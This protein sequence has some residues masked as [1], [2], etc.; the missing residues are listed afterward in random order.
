MKIRI[1]FVS[2]SS[3]SSFVCLGIK[4]KDESFGREQLIA[5][6]EKLNI[7]NKGL[8]KHEYNEWCYNPKSEFILGFSA[9]T[10]GCS[11]EWDDVKEK[12][13]ILEK[14]KK[15][16]NTS[17]KITIYGSYSCDN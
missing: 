2:N 15:E 5:L 13:E 11:L 12:I 6:Q 9:D 8:S 17:A 10:V 4:I 14:V 7:S 3:S 16:L 1:G